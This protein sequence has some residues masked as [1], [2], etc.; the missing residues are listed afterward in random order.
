[1]TCAL[2]LCL[3]LGYIEILYGEV[4]LRRPYTNFFADPDPIPNT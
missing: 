4:V 3:I 2:R 1:M